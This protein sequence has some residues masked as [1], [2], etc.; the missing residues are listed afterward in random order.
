MGSVNLFNYGIPIL[1]ALVAIL[2]LRQLTI[3]HRAHARVVRAN[4]RRAMEEMRKLRRIWFFDT[5]N[6]LL[7]DSKFCHSKTYNIR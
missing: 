3:G 4:Q 2:K 1:G 5:G 6:D 7:P